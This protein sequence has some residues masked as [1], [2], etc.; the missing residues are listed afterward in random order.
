M[1]TGIGSGPLSM[2]QL[3][4]GRKRAGSQTR[5]CDLSLQGDD[6]AADRVAEQGEVQVDERCGRSR[7]LPWGLRPKRCRLRQ[8]PAEGGAWLCRGAK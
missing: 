4:T 3:V 1:E 5:S 2:A 8:S 6:D 7:R